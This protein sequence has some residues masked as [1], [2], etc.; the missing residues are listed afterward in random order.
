MQ[1]CC[2]VQQK[3]LIIKQLQ[4]LHGLKRKCYLSGVIAR[5]VILIWVAEPVRAVRS[6]QQARGGS[7]PGP[8]SSP[9]TRL[10]RAATQNWI[11]EELL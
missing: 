5:T 9:A 7:G 10:V 6:H 1:S 8:A 3:Y 2:V 4:I 11:E